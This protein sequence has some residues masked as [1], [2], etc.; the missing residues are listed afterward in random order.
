LQCLSSWSRESISHLS[1]FLERH[2]LRKSSTYGFYFHITSMTSAVCS[3]TPPIILYDTTQ[4]HKTSR[5]RLQHTWSLLTLLRLNGM[6]HVNH[7]NILS[8]RWFKYDRDKLWL[9]YTQIVP[10]IFEPP[11]TTASTVHTVG[12][13]SVSGQWRT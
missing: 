9:V 6:Q 2:Y 1:L 11:C 13:L 5:K 3:N 4:T 8:T 12:H 7:H 10:V